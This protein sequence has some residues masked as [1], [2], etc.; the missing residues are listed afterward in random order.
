MPQDLNPGASARY[1]E[2]LA[3]MTPAQRL[4]STRQLCRGVR[5]AAMLALRARHPDASD[6]ELRARLAARIY[7]RAAAA[8]LFRRLPDDAV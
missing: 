1:H 4:E 6:E 8:R 5:R 3:A 7:G 2:L